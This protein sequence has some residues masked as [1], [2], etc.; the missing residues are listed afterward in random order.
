MD[1]MNYGSGVGADENW[2]VEEAR[3][4]PRFLGKCEA[5]FALGNGYMGQR[6]ATEERYVGETRGLFVAGSFNK[7]AEN[8]VTELP[9]A[10]DFLWLDIWLDG[11][12]FSLSEGK[13]LSYR[14][15]LHL[16]NAELVRE[17]EWEAPGG[18]AFRLRFRRFVSMSDIHLVAMRVEIESIS[19]AVNVALESGINGRMTN[20]G[21]QHFA[22]GDARFYDYKVMQMTQKTVQSGIGFAYSGAHL[23][24]MGD[25]PLDVSG[26]IHMD[27]RQVFFRYEGIALGKGQCLAVE[28]LVNVFT[29]RD[30]D[31]GGPDLAGLKLRSLEHVRAAT[32]SSYGAL[33]AE[34]RKA[35]KEKVWD[36][37]PIEV[38]SKTPYDQLALRFAQYHL[39]VM[40]PAH[41]GRMGIGAKGLS[42]E[43]YKGHS[44]WDTEI[45]I[46]PYFTYTMPKVARALLEY[47][48]NT[49][50]GARR[51]AAENGYSGAMFPWESAWIDDGE[52]TPL[53]GAADI[54]SGEPIKIWSGIIEQH[55]TS[56]VAYAVWQYFQATGD[57]GFMEKCG[58]ELILDTAKFWSSRLEYDERKGAYCINGV[59]GPDEYKE[60]IDN[61]A[62]T[63]YMARWNI[64]KAVECHDKIK[65]NAPTLFESLRVK[66]G[67]DEAYPLWTERVGKIYLP[68]PRSGDSV[69]PQDDT[70]L[71]K[72]SIDLSKYKNQENVGSIYRDYNQEQINAIQVSKQ[73]DVMAMFY[74]LPDLFD[75]DVKRANWEYYEPRT[76]HDS[77]LSLSTHAALACDM[78]DLPMAYNLFSHATRIDLGP[79]MKTSDS[80]IHAASIGGIWQCAV[81]GFGGVRVV[82]GE[83][84]VSPKLP[85]QWSS[86][87]FPI[88]W[89]GDRLTIEATHSG[90]SIERTAAGGGAVKGEIPVWVYGNKLNLGEKLKVDRNN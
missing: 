32:R 6:A 70:Y 54:V 64:L 22:D 43:G 49:L 11:R 13:I 45:F 9:N 44:F 5:V 46:L 77:S 74:L 10:A 18:G 79:N 3:F 61:N 83:L 58:Y 71:D 80:G 20:G 72:K 41:D 2:I 85:T 68:R 47:R 30:L 75:D 1:I 81:N 14:R 48:Y 35:W 51:K 50:S 67:L 17:V 7:F 73:A 8:E 39:A 38:E 90:V 65:A 34:H 69:I 62:F 25:A 31:F 63:N 12:R 82:S 36:A 59:M 23:F 89:R 42:G 33:F 28:K 53:W 26:S 4:D 78:D 37:A 57:S 55:I 88:I 24:Y 84:R 60:H 52:V 19:G 87:R 76:L 86:F 15:F 29:D 21:S 27:R 66:L 16:R 40:A 56:D